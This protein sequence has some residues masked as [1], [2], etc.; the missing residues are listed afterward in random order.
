MSHNWLRLEMDLVWTPIEANSC[1]HSA[2]SV[3]DSTR[4]AWIYSG[5]Y[6]QKVDSVP[7]TPQNAK[8][9]PITKLREVLTPEVS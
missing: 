2:W 8:T 9:K 1:P 4:A 3:G 5:C 6:R 7:P